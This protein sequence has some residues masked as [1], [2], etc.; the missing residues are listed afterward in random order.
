[1]W[2]G[3]A[4]VALVGLL[5]VFAWLVFR[6]LYYSNAQIV[7]LSAGGYHPLRAPPATFAIEQLDALRSLGP[8]LARDESEPGPVVGKGLMEASPATMRTM[9]PVLRDATPEGESVLIVYIDAH[10]VSDDGTAYLLCRN[11]DPTNPAAGRYALGDLLAQV[12]DSPAAVKLLV[13]DAGRIPCDP[14]LGM[15]VNEFP[16]LL[17]AAVHATNDPS[18]WVLSSSADFQRSHDSSGLEQ[19]IFG[20]FVAQGLHGAADL[21]GDHTINIDE[22]HRYVAANTSA[23]VRQSSGGHESQ[24]PVLLWGGGDNP[25]RADFPVLLPVQAGGITDLAIPSHVGSLPTIPGGEAAA[26]YTSRAQGDLAPITGNASRTA[27]K[28]IPGGR[29]IKRTVKTTKKVSKR[30]EQS[31]KKAAAQKAAEE[32]APASGAMPENKPKAEG[33]AKPK[34]EGQASEA[35]PQADGKLS[36]SAPAAGAPAVMELPASPE[37][38]IAA[39]WK[40]RDDL[41]TAAEDQPRAVDYA[42]Q[43]WHEFQTWLLD[44]EQLNRAGGVGNPEAIAESL[45]KLLPRLAKLPNVPPLD[46]D[47][48]PDLAA[49]MAALAP[50]APPE[51][52]HPWS[53]AM[54]QLLAERGGPPLTPEATAASQTFDRFTRD[55]TSA[56]LSAWVAKLNPRL[57]QFAELRLARAIARD[58][59]LDWSVAQT[60]LAAER[61]AQQV[62]TIDPALLP[63]IGWRI[64]GADRLRLEGLRLLIDGLGGDRQVRAAHLLRRAIDL[65]K[66]AADEAG[67]VAGAIELRDDLFNRVPY[68][69]AMC[70]P[71]GLTVLEGTPPQAALLQLIARLNDL[72]T[73]IDPGNPTRL[74]E[75]R[76]RMAE[77]SP[78]VDHVEAG[79]SEASVRMLTGR[80]APTDQIPRIERLLSTPLPDAELRARLLA[81]L[82]GAEDRMANDFRPVSIPAKAEPRPEPTPEQWRQVVARGELEL[83]LA[84]LAVGGGESGGRTLEPLQTAYAALTKAA[85]AL[86]ATTR[87]PQSSDS[88]WTAA[89]QMGNATKDFYRSLPG[90][91]DSAVEQ[92]SGQSDAAAR[93]ARLLVLRRAMRTVRLVDA[94]DVKSLGAADPSGLLA[95]AGWYDLLAWQQRR[96]ETALADAPPSEVAY[97]SDAARSYRAQAEQIPHQPPLGALPVSAL[98]LTGPTTVSLTTEPEQTI[99]VGLRS[100]EATPADVW[101]MFDYDSDLVELSLPTEPTVYR[102]PELK[103]GATALTDEFPLLPGRRSLPPTYKLPAGGSE[104]LHFKLRAKPGARET[105]QLIVKAIAA[106]AYVRHETR[107]VLPPPD[108]VELAIEGLPGTWTPS[109]SRLLLDPFPNRLTEY[110]VGLVNR[111]TTDRRVDVELLGVEHAPAVPPP[112]TALAPAEAAEMV[113]RFGATIPLATLGDVAVAAGGKPVFLPF[114]KPAE[115]PKAAAP[116]EAK[117][118]AGNGAKPGGDAAPPAPPITTPLAHGLLLVVTDRA[119]HSKTVR[120]LDVAVQRPRRYVHPQVG[121]NLDR[122]RIEIRIRPQDKSLLPPDG[123]R[124]RAEIVPPLPTGAESELDGHLDPSQEE[125]HLMAEVPPESGKVLT[126][127]LSVDGYP[128]AFVYRVPCGVQSSEVPEETDLREVRIT[129]PDADAAFKA[130]VDHIPVDCQVDAPLG[131]FSIASPDDLFEI[132]IDVHRQRDLRGDPSLRI[133]ADRQVQV[134]LARLAPGGLLVLDARVSDFHLEV[135]APALRMRESMSWAAS[136]PAARRAGASR[137]KSCSTDRH[138]ASN[139]SSCIRR[140]SPS[141]RMSRFRCGRRTKN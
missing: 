4:A 30:I 98:E 71:T 66:Q 36:T 138:R 111:G 105:T 84:R 44:Q 13:L 54:A 106:G 69:I 75:V 99:E 97:I 82:A 10:G 135:P 47:V 18:L 90:L 132:G 55:G 51:V 56:E 114:P 141:G 100:T 62:A 8:V 95:A 139:G 40:L 125:L 96:L 93:S 19:S 42:P 126:V 117:P 85:A 113:G 27:T 52:D 59:G 137:S 91:V 104:T 110:R 76:N 74:E 38:L 101:L 133:A 103:A 136:T 31:E 25:S 67:D 15:L 14:R 22:L 94:R 63:W 122:G 83:A 108:M 17:A 116:P 26:P 49:R 78:L 24:T 12:Q 34:A 118:Q 88:L 73:A 77:L 2:R 6:P 68:Y 57:D 48:A 20:F 46:D 28:K 121:F 11:F 29:A 124:V 50:R 61:W 9:A 43:D 112:T 64:D 115:A 33:E 60:A 58:A 102:Q 130:P 16:R 41:E 119:T 92:Q 70:R 86:D 21:N 107:I 128:R 72:A 39:A 37:E 120:W 7:F 140:S 32:A 80:T 35:K 123:I 134:G 23:W 5:G 127:R 65:Y 1:M 87:D 53:L 81:A 3:L 79:L 45:K 89:R 131:A 129:S 109:D